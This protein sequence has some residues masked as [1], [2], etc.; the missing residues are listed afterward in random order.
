MEVR[1]RM[2]VNVLM[3]SLPMHDLFKDMPRFYAPMMWFEQS[4]KI[5]SD[6]GFMLNILLVLSDIGIGV[7]YS[8]AGIGF[9]MVFI[10]FIVVIRRHQKKSSMNLS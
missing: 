1:A 10:R 5:T 9:F 8:I 2:Q 6:L 4:A 7:F 3:R